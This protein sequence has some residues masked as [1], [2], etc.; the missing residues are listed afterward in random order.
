MRSQHFDIGFLITEG[1]DE[2]LFIAVSPGFEHG[3]GIQRDGI[4]SPRMTDPHAVHAVTAHFGLQEIPRQTTTNAFVQRAGTRTLYHH[5]KDFIERHKD[6]RVVGVQSN[7]DLTMNYWHVSYIRDYHGPHRSV[8]CA[9]FTEGD[10][11]QE[12]TAN[13][14]YRS[15]VK[16]DPV[17]AK[18]LGRVYD[19]VDLKF[20]RIIGGS[21]WSV[22]AADTETIIL[23]DK[24]FADLEMY[25]SGTHDISSLIEFTLSGKTIVERGFD[26]SL[27]K[28]IDK[29]DDVRHVFNLPQADASGQFH[30]SPIKSV[31]LGEYQLFKFLNQRRA[32]LYTP[33]IVNLD[34]E[35]FVQ[36]DSAKVID[37][38]LE[39]HCRNSD[40]SPTRRGQFARYSEDELEIFFPHNVYPFGVIGLR[41]A[42]APGGVELVGLSSGGL[43]GRVG[44][45]LEGITQIMYDFFGCTDALV[46][47]EGYDVF[48]VTNPAIVREV[49]G[50]SK[51]VD[52]AYTNEQLLNKV[53]GFTAQRAK[54]DAAEA[55]AQSA[56][57]VYGPDM[58]KW[59]L[60]ERYFAELIENYEKHETSD[61]SDIM[62][63]TPNRSQMR[64]VLIYAVHEDQLSKHLSCEVSESQPQQQM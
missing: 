12:E 1:A 32:A 26:I 60:N 9:L 21:G 17:A 56:Q 50:Q 47:D 15:L 14:V 31:N 7:G 36:V 62:T 48:M 3:P 42:S 54:M 25:R 35:G 37:K 23:Y 43:S 57:Y 39:R 19:A 5:L 29:F 18:V 44:N 8:L 13:R 4:G 52:Y 11:Q 59:P 6:W 24:I 16:W 27:S 28:A 64:S 40:E 33:I 58:M 63:V 61:F 45:T 10:P 2:H 34:I 41:T 20:S 49:K 22:R 30:G 55:K 53:L 51:I 38:L 46:L